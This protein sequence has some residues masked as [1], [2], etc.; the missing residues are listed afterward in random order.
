M[1][2]TVSSASSMVFGVGTG[3]RDGFGAR[4]GREAIS[5]QDIGFFGVARLVGVD[6]LDVGIG[7]A[8]VVR[9]A[10]SLGVS[11]ADSLGVGFAVSLAGFSAFFW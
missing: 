3:R 5:A 8:G 6:C 9:T 11:S 10:V 4:T 1:T 7:V 2:D